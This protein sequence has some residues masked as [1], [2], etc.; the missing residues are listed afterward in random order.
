MLK[1][2]QAET[3]EHR[4]HAKRLFSEHLEWANSMCASELGTSFDVA[5]VVEQAMAKLDKL[6]PPDGRLLLAQWG[7]ETAGCGCL[8][9]IG[10]GVG[11]IKRMYVRPEHRGKGIGRSLLDALLR[12]ALQIGYST[13]RL[14]TAPF[15]KQAQT[16]YRS[17]GFKDVGPYARTEIPKELH[18]RWLFMELSLADVAADDAAESR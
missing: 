11:E 9:K 7:T 2:H 8:W 12:E 14:D 15:M 16:L 1:I 13:V 4:D 17:V 5:A 3:D 18:A 6:S 10:D